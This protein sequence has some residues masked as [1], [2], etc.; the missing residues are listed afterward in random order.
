MPR[1][2]PG[3]SLG[4]CAAALLAGGCSVDKPQALFVD[5]DRLEALAPPAPAGIFSTPGLQ[6]L[7]ASSGSLAALPEQ[8][9][10]SEDSRALSQE[11]WREVQA[12]REKLFQDLK[13]KLTLTY[14]SEVQGLRDEKRLELAEREQERLEKVWLVIRSKFEAL[15]AKTGPLTFRLSW[16]SGFPDPDPNSRRRSTQDQLRQAQLA[17]SAELRKQIKGLEDAYRD[18]V[19]ALLAN[20]AAESD[21]ALAKVI[22]EE[23][24]QDGDLIR[25]AEAEARRRAA[26]ALSAISESAFTP[27]SSLPAQPAALAQGAAAQAKRPQDWRSESRSPWP[28]RAR[29]KDEA[30]IFVRLQGGTWSSTSKGAKDATQEFLKW[31]RSRQ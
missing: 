29:L 11:A 16:L 6:G 19:K 23:K 18:E 3:I 20:L 1:P 5:L 10:L 4:L 17:E 8:I 26:Q 28:L 9:T 31:R 15:A 13:R 7:K 22:E 30:M 21:S 24:L 25:Q 12:S 2:L 27:E 14:L